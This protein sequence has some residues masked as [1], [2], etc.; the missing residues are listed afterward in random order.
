MGCEDAQQ[1]KGRL[2][3]KVLGAGMG[4]SKAHP[5]SRVVSNSRH[6]TRVVLSHT[7]SLVILKLGR[8]KENSPARVVSEI[9]RRRAGSTARPSAR[10]ILAPDSCGRKLLSTAEKNGCSTTNIP[11]RAGV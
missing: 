6:S 8:G 4:R 11:C 2:T 9:A 10:A 3:L 7:F 1:R 5:T